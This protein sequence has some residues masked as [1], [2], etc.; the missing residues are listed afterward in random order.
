MLGLAN[1]V[2]K[3]PMQALSTAVLLSVLTIWIAPIGLLVGAIIGLV[4]LRIGVNDGLKTLLWSSVAIIGVTMT[5]TGSYW[6]AVIA[7]MEYMLPIWVMAMVLRNTNSL[8]RTLQLAMIMAGTGVIAFYLL[9]PSPADWWLTMFNQQ[10]KPV[11]DASQVDY[12]LESIQDLSNM[13]TMLLASF[14]VTLWF[15]I[16]LIA[17]WWQG[18][19]YHPGQFQSDFFQLSLPKSVA[20]IAVALAILGLVLGQ[21]SGL[22]FDLSGVVIAGLMFQGLAILHQTVAVKQLHKAWLVSLYVALFLFPQVML[23]LATIGLVDIWTDIRSRW[24]QE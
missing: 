13:I 20:L 11:L 17:R 1:F 7:I 6:P 9:I 14:A 3:G 19:L 22:I 12:S 4:T 5:T 21:E 24:E 23:I 18:A 10:I 8:A 16:V 2:M 15:S